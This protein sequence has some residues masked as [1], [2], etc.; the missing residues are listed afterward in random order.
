LDPIGLHVASRK[1]VRRRLRAGAIRDLRDRKG[2]SQVELA[3]LAKIDPGT[4]SRL[5]RGLHVPGPY[6]LGTI[7]GVLGVA[8]EDVLEMPDGGATVWRREGG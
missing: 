7:C 4:I 6:T 3:I 2:L 8:V 1:R 5:E